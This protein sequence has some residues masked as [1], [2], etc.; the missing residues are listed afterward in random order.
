MDTNFFKDLYNEHPEYISIRKAEGESYEKYVS[1]VKYWKLKYLEELIKANN[2]EAQL[3]T[4]VEIGCATGVLL[5]EFLSTNSSISKIGFDISDENINSAKQQYPSINFQN[6]PIQDFMEVNKDIDIDIVIL[7]DILEHVEND[8]EFLNIAG[9]Y[10]KYVLINLPI[11]KVPEY[12]GREYGVDDIEGHL[13]A[14]SVDDAIKMCENAGVKII[15]YKVMQ[16]VLEP[17][18][19]NYLLQKLTNKYQDKTEALISYL[20]EL[21]EIKM[22]KDFYKKNFFALGIK[23]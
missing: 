21:N 23:K 17:V 7:S 18:F 5:N 1:D 13:R 15:E 2:I 12:E 4:V 9:R 6:S 16:Y 20:K 8:V 10:S 19:N 14:Y 22:N 3:K 11:E